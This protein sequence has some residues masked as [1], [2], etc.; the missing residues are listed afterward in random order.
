MIKGTTD[1]DS[2]EMVN[3]QFER[4]DKIIEEYESKYSKI[5]SDIRITIMVIE[6]L[7]KPN[8]KVVAHILKSTKERRFTADVVSNGVDLNSYID[9]FN[10]YKDTLK[11]IQITVDSVKEIH[12]KRRISHDKRGSFEVIMNN[13]KLVTQN[14]IKS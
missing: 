5:E 2:I 3:F 6:P 10:E 1:I 4:I 8:L 14:S 9:L 11:H 7:L 12:D 13:I